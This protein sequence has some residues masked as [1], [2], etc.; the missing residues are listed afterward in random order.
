MRYKV[1]FEVDGEK[2]E[3]IF[4][5]FDEEEKA[6]LFQEEYTTRGYKNVKIVTYEEIGKCS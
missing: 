2:K 5:G 6:K 4:N 3:T 1:N